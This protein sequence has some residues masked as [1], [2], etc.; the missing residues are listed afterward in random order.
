VRDEGDLHRCDDIVPTI[1]D[2]QEQL[3]RVAHV[4]AGHH[5]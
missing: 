4:I 2:D 1:D 5:D 3:I